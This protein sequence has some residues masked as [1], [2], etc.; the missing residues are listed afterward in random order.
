MRE[1]QRRGRRGGGK[2]GEEGR[3]GQRRGRRGGGKKGKERE[4]DAQRQHMVIGTLALLLIFLCEQ[5]SGPEGDRR[6]LCF[7][8]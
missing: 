4:L 3:E 7:V 2:G 6:E 1:R 8:W 5:G